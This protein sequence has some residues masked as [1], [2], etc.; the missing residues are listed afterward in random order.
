MGISSKQQ[1]HRNRINRESDAIVFE[2]HINKP[3]S[4]GV[5]RFPDD[6]E[7][8]YIKDNREISDENIDLSGSFKPVNNKNQF[9]SS[10]GTF[11]NCGTRQSGVETAVSSNSGVFIYPNG[12]QVIFSK[13]Q[14][15]QTVD[16][17]G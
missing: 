16:N 12:T 9:S 4:D 11:A 6:D 2:G 5:I 14:V 17:T 8:K 3:Q 7:N 10:T 15:I 1:I 13:C